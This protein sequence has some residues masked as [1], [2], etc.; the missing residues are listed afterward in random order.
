MCPRCKS[1]PRLKTREKPNGSGYCNVCLSEWQKERAKRIKEE[2]DEIKSR[3]CADCGVQYPPHVMD[4]D[5]IGDDK[6]FNISRMYSHSREAIMKEI[7]KCEV[8]C[9]N[10]HRIR[11]HARYSQLVV[12]AASL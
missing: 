3:P 10:C 7:Q 11:T 6:A 8:V 1:R 12:S 2:V 4:F 9:S 5:H